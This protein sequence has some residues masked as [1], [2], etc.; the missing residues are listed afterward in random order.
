VASHRPS[1]VGRLIRGP[2]AVMLFHKLEFA[3]LFLLTFARAIRGGSKTCCWTLFLKA[4]RLPPPD[5]ANLDWVAEVLKGEV[6]EPIAALCRGRD[7]A[8]GFM[9]VPNENE[10]HDCDAPSPERRRFRR[11][12][13][14]SGLAWVDAT[15]YSRGE[16]DGTCFPHDKHPT[17]KGP[18]V[19]ARALRDLVQRAVARHAQPMTV[20]GES[21]R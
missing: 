10:L 21:A 1:V 13:E 17:V 5:A 3:V 9:D 18:G 8:C 19:F 7:L 15:P 12:F 2:Q 16:E 11:L 14:G 6:V 20:E 4:R